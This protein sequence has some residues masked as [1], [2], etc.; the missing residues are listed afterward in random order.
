MH[1]FETCVIA[2]NQHRGDVEVVANTLD[3][4]ME[5]KPRDNGNHD[6]LVFRRHDNVLCAHIH[7]NNDMA[8]DWNQEVI[9]LPT[10]HP[11]KDGFGTLHRLCPL[12]GT[13]T[14]M[15]ASAIEVYFHAKQ[16]LRVVQ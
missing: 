1:D 4:R 14:A 10:I 6:V 9:A 15:P 13:G 7:G 2:G 8:F 11:I 5:C 3:Y 12:T 16:E